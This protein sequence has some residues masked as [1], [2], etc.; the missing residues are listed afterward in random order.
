M[1]KMILKNFF[2]SGLLSFIGTVAVAEPI[3]NSDSVVIVGTTP[4]VMICSE[5]KQVGR[6]ETQPFSFSVMEQS[7]LR[8]CGV[9]GLKDASQFAA[10]L[11]IPDYGSKLTSA[12]YIRGIGS[13]IGSPAVGMQVD[14][15]S[16]AEKSAFDFDFADVQRVEVLRGP[17]S[18]LY[19]RNSMGGLLR[20][21]TFNPL[22]VRQTGSFT[23]IRLGTSTK[24]AGRYAQVLRAGF[25]GKNSAYS[26]SAY[27]R[28]ND[29]YNRNTYLQQRSNGIESAG[30]KFR[31]IYNSLKN[32]GFTSDFQ[33]SLQYTDEDGYDYYNV[34]D[35]LIQ[36][37]E[38]GGY[39]RTLL[40]TSLRL[41]QVWQHVTFASVTAWQFLRDRMMMDQDF[42]P[43]N[44]Y[45][46][47]QR[48]Q[49][50]QLSQEFTLKSQQGTRLEWLSGI[51]L[52]KQWLKT[53]APVNFGSD[54]VARYIQSGID[55][56][57]TSANA[58]M[59]PLGMALSMN[60]T[61]QNLLVNGDFKTPLFNAAGFL[62]ARLKDII[63]QGLD[64]STGLRLDYEHSRLNYLS[65][66]TSHFNFAMS[67]GG[68]PLLQQSFTT[69]SYYD[70]TIRK[71]YTQLLPRFAVSYNFGERTKENMLYLSISKGFRAGGYNVQLFSDLVQSA[72]RNDMMRTLANDPHLGS[73]LTHY[74]Q[75]AD[76][77]S[78][79][80]ATVYKPETS[81]NY[82]LGTRFHLF[83]HN[84][85]IA[86]SL[87]Y[88]S[89]R[90]QQIA[91]FATNGFGRQMINAGKSESYGAEVELKANV[92]L[93]NHPLLLTAA[94]GYTHSTFREY[95]AGTSQGITYIYD[96][97][98]V[99]FAP[100]HNMN[101]V[102]EYVVPIRE[103]YLHIGANVTGLGRIYW[104]EDNAVSQPFYILLGAHLG[105]DY[106]SIRLNLWG[107][108]LTSTHY[109]PFQF[110][111]MG[112]YYAQKCRPIQFGID[113]DY[114]F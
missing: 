19:G 100:I 51:Y 10:N 106:K 57:F 15:V 82:E 38:Q 48:Q 39:R 102:A 98:Y 77:P 85:T 3:E 18:T 58:A 1:H 55:K 96:G 13:R 94:Y 45:T 114:A 75:I 42:S 76:K 24:D 2:L 60:V 27:Y 41:E 46:L 29:G 70:G 101:F 6:L 40:N 11:Y 84:L 33:T 93:F 92:P 112:Q 21:Y 20:I 49:S 105:A 54:G 30:A 66:T 68:V 63:F 62:H 8:Q 34:T 83:N 74:V 35:G 47:E 26:A 14:G 97:N 86:A 32:S 109:V 56:G 50:H 22:S 72:L 12:I 67:H 61:D 91:R 5:V 16:F 95:D 81:W 65:G 111:S 78:A 90:N 87:F 73:Y 89:T 17:Q 108:N 107:K 25:A 36:E 37:N 80:S 71:N 64:L 69:D 99:P 44:I 113:L 53:N 103:V 9:N 28:G 7:S 43:L 23:H 31:Y 59:N 88:I 79:D 4:T 104:T 110:L 52:S